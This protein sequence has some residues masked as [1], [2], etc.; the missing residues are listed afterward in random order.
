VQKSK[1]KKAKSEPRENV[2]AEGP[3]VVAAFICE[4]VLRETDGVLSAI[5]IVDRITHSVHV[6]GG[7]PPSQMPPISVFLTFVLILKSGNAKGS[8]TLAIQL[9]DPEGEEIQ[10]R[11]QTIVFEGEDDRGINM[12]A[13]L[14]LQFKLPGLYWFEVYLDGWR[15][16]RT[17]LRI[18]YLPSASGT[19]TEPMKIQ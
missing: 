3:H 8:K 7:E 4:Q 16:T 6:K 11:T 5:R 12:Q 13:K 18:V 19:T 15:I 9:V 17:P 10:K 1:K 14:N 2:F